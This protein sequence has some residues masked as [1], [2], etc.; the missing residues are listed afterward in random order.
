M[1]ATGAKSWGEITIAVKEWQTLARK[2]QELQQKLDSLEF[3]GTAAH[4]A[5]AV[6]VDGQQRPKSLSIS[7]EAAER[8]EELGAWIREAQAKATKVSH[9]EMTEKLR[10][11][12]A[13]HFERTG[14]SAEVE[15]ESIALA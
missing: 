11:L 1:G 14:V 5:V 13:S 8:N 2:T 3:E 9:D 10:E 4:G 6:T 12:Y 7:S 15:A